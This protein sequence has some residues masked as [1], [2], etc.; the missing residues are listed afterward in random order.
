M[1]VKKFFESIKQNQEIK[2]LDLAN[3]LIELKSHR[4]FKDYYNGQPIENYVYGIYLRDTKKLIGFCDL[5]LG[6]QTALMYLG[7]VGYSIFHHYRGHNYAFQATE[8]LLRLAVYLKVESVMITVNPDNEP[9][10]RTIE[11]L[12]SEYIKRVKVPA[13]EPLFQQGDYEKLIY[14]ISL[15]KGEMNG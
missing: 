9:S 3:E 13:S 5:R 15:T 1:K 8:L 7:N 6:D 12:D 4:I 10:I 2:E 14:R 11:K